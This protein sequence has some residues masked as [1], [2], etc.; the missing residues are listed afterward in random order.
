MVDATASVAGVGV[1]VDAGQ[2]AEVMAAAGLEQGSLV[3]SWQLG[4]V[5]SH[6]SRLPQ[7]RSAAMS[8]LAS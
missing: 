2:T 8:V 6:E 4:C 3:L 7:H 1:V 5:T